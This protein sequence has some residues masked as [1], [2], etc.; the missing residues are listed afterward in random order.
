MQDARYISPE[1]NLLDVL[2]ET[3]VQWRS[4]DPQCGIFV[5][6]PEADQSPVTVLQ[7]ECVRLNIPLA[8][9][10]FPSLIKAG[11]FTISGLWLLKMVSG[12][13]STLVGNLDKEAAT[14]ARQIIQAIEP[15]LDAPGKT[16]FM[17]FDGMVPNISSILDELYLHL[18]DLVH[19]AGINAGSEHF[20]PMDCLFDAQHWLGNGVLCLLLPPELET[21]LAHGYEAP[22]EH[23]TATSSLGNR[24]SSIDWQP[25]FTVYQAKIKQH[26]N[27]DLNRENFYQY[28]VH[29][30][31]GIILANQVLVRIPVGLDEDGVILCAGEVPDYAVMTLLQAPSPENSLKTVQSIVDQLKCVSSNVPL[32]SF[33]CAGRRMHMGASAELELE[34]LAQATGTTLIGALSLGEIGSLHNLTYPF[35]HNGTLVCATWG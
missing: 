33:Y 23:V 10:I 6:L 29:F 21:A 27:I 1:E 4:A 11:G 25:A 16:L 12:S 35:F 14:V 17:V 9:G 3:L 20:C 22:A 15:Q 30:P 31:F 13:A 34:A 8:G 7:A 5:L 19:Y 2:R 28:A 18:G 24:I 32:L 26:Y